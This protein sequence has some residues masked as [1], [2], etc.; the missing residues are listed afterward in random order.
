MK[1]NILITGAA[2]FLGSF[3]C[4]E[5]LAAG[6]KV[7]GVD[8]FFRGTPA[9]ISALTQTEFI[10]E[11]L[12]LSIA[13]NSVPLQKIMRQHHIE[14]VVHL[15]AINGTQYFYDEPLFVFEQNIKITQTLLAAM[16]TTAV[17]YVIYSSSSEVYGNPL[18]IPTDEKQPILLNLEAD[19]D[20]YAAS[21]AADD[22][23]VRLFAKHHHMS[24]LILRI[25]NLY[26]ERMVGTKYGQV[27]AEFVTRMLHE[28]QFTLIGDGSQTRSFC[29]V[30]DA[31][32]AIKQLIEHHITGLVNVGN[33]EEI[34]ILKL[35][36]CLH[37][38]EKIPFHPVFLAPRAH[39]HQRRRP[40]ISHL[41]SL[42]PD[43]KFTSL[44]TGLKKVIKY[45]RTQN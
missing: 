11:D 9:N 34:S 31:T 37:S 29:Y 38:L 39:D 13:T 35:A 23:Y 42:I 21:K 26:G 36:Q 15:A 33:D 45:Y 40:D 19:R 5:L 43:L 44:E 20:S 3:L 18:N 25:F 16:D 41:R 7:V 4:E 10:L 22:F 1:K 17:N 27:V 8:N 30:K 32:W 12:D 2:G 6:Y 28:D 14:I 24:F